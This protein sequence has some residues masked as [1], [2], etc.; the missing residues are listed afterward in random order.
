MHARSGSSARARTVEAQTRCVGHDL[1]S[2]Q[3]GATPCSAGESIARRTPALHPTHHTRLQRRRG[4]EHQPVIHVGQ[5]HRAANA[6]HVQLGLE[7]FQRVQGPRAILL[8]VIMLHQRLVL[9][10]QDRV[11]ECW[12]PGP[13][14]AKLLPRSKASVEGESTST[15]T[16][17]FS[18]ISRAWSWNC[19]SLF[20]D[21]RVLKSLPLSFSVLRGVTCKVERFYRSRL[22]SIPCV[23]A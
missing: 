15:M 17:G 7:A 8:S 4:G 1:C 3:D 11:D 10:D 2:A 18:S 12:Q 22:P 9:R 23:R 20:L 6:G 19:R 5:R 14:A 13:R 16:V 21:S